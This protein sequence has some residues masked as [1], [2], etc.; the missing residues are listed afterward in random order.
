MTYSNTEVY[1]GKWAR[2]IRSLLLFH[3]FEALNNVFEVQFFS[4]L[5]SFLHPIKDTDST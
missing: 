3:Y 4:G 2:W 5:K 1:D